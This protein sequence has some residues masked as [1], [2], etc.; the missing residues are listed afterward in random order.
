MINV[1]G[2]E[3]FNDGCKVGELFNE[4]SSNTYDFREWLKDVGD[5]RDYPSSQD[6]EDFE[7]EIVELNNDIGNLEGEINNLEERVEDLSEKI[8]EYI[9]A[10]AEIHELIEINTPKIAVNKIAEIAQEFCNE[11]AWS[12]CHV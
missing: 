11:D 5:I 3:I 9:E 1:I 10:F 8:D 4:N 6:R 12:G 7:R 2:K